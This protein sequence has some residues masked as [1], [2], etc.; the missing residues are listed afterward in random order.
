MARRTMILATLFLVAASGEGRANPSWSSVNVEPGQDN[1]ILGLSAVDAQHAWAL[2][3]RN[4]GQSTS[5]VGLRTTNGSTFQQMT[6]P[7]AT[8]PMIPAMFFAIAFE[9]AQTGYLAGMV[10]L[11]SKIY[12]TTDGGANWT[13][14]TTTGS[15]L[16]HFQILLG[17]VVYGVAGSDFVYS[18]DGQ[19]FT[20]VAVPEPSANVAPAGVFMLN[21]SCGWLVG[22]WGYDQDNHPVPSDGAVWYTD[23]G[24]DSWS[25]IAESLPFH[26]SRAHFVAADLGFA[27]GNQGEQGVIARTTDGG[28]TWTPIPLPDHPALPDVCIMPGACIDEAQPISDMLDIKFWDAERGIALGLACTSPPCDRGDSAA[29][30]LSSFLRTYDGGQ[31]WVHDADYEPAMPDVNIV[32]MTLPGE[33]AKQVTM[34]FADPN[35]GFLGGQHNMILR[36]EADQPEQPESGGLPSCDSTSGTDGGAPFGDGGSTANPDGTLSGC[37]CT[38]ATGGASR[39]ALLLMVLLGL[40]LRRRQK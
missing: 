16:S 30:Y 5:I 14:V 4:D 19:T 25:V 13:E 29:S 3:A 23:D 28:H 2:A 36:Y 20:T 6:L 39:P 34:A 38:S 15:L 9:S 24:G 11:A 10:D 31:T 22:G 26:L 27:V 7:Q 1:V 37:G 21:Q 40:Y 17:G 18:A 32:M 8:N 35:H 33:L 12:R